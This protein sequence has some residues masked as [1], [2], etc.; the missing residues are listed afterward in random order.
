VSLGDPQ[1][2]GRY[3]LIRLVGAGGMAT[4]HLAQQIGPQGFV[5]PCV[6]KRIAEPFA[7]D[8]KYRRMF[9]Q[10]ARLS[11]LLNHP[12]VVQTFDFGEVENV[13][14]MAMELVDGVNLSVLCRGLAKMNRWIPL[15]ASV[16]ICVQVC[17]ALHYAHHMTALD[18][19]KLNLVHRDV[20]PQN[21][22]VSRQG[23]VKLAD[24]GIARH[25][26]R[27]EV[28]MGPT[29][30]GKPG[31]MAPEQAMGHDL[32]GR[33]DVFAVGVVLCEL[34]SA[35]RVN[36]GIE[37]PVSIIGLE[38]R[39]RELCAVRSEAPASLV[40]LTARLA[41]IDMAK[42][43][44][45]ARQVGQLLRAEADKL[46]AKDGLSGFLHRVFDRYFP[47]D[48]LP[49]AFHGSSGS[50]PMV[51]EPDGAAR[52]TKSV[53]GDVVEATEDQRATLLQPIDESIDEPI[54]ATSL[55]A[56][57]PDLM[58][59]PTIFPA[60][61]DEAPQQVDV[62][63][64]MWTQIG[65]VDEQPAAAFAGWP[66]EFQGNAQA[67]AEVRSDT[68]RDEGDAEPPPRGVS[69]IPALQFE[70]MPPSLP[71]PPADPS[72][73]ALA[74]DS[75]PAP[76]SGT[77]AE[78]FAPVGETQLDIGDD[79]IQPIAAQSQQTGPS[80]GPRSG[81]G[82]RP[83]AVVSPLSPPSQSMA[84]LELA[85]PA[86]K[87][88]VATPAPRSP[89]ED[90]V[91]RLGD[92]MSDSGVMTKVLLGIGAALLIA[93][94]V[95]AWV[96]LSPKA[97]PVKVA[98]GAI[99]VDSQP[100]GAEVLINGVGDGRFTPTTLE[101]LP[102]DVPIKLSARLK[103]Y[104]PVPVTK[105]VVIPA[106]MGRTDAFFEMAPAHV[107]T[108]S[109]TPPGAKVT[110]NGEAV[111]GRSPLDLPEVA[112]GD[113]ATIT[114]EL[115]TFLSVRRVL[116]ATPNAPTEVP[117]ALEKARLIEI[118]SDP[119]GAT[120]FLDDRE[121]GLTPEFDVPVP[122]VSAFNVRLERQG[123][124][125]WQRD[126]IGSKLTEDRVEAEL[127][128]V[129]LLALPLRREEREEARSLDRSLARFRSEIRKAKRK[130][131]SRLAQVERLSGDHTHVGPVVKAQNAADDVQKQVDQLE[132]ELEEA[133]AD[134]EEFRDRVLLRLEHS[135]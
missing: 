74:K 24:F 22:L 34:I 104:L 123:F 39:V 85:R 63:R 35:R 12:N 114:I 119:P 124:K 18:G 68:V 16:E 96:A 49:T 45:D 76:P 82:P 21:I 29:S 23:G 33:A 100:P 99:S 135:R 75:L 26:D 65:M 101:G 15:R 127:A 131:A 120:L 92:A 14:Y 102:V 54:D 95:A 28:T 98:G 109:T 5:K 4:V 107:F 59:A 108:I 38:D 118:A 56:A 62:V 93:G 10:E 89:M 125:K 88:E 71:A 27:I 37:G 6:L 86:P 17:D 40:D 117:I 64:D 2:F 78:A 90:A 42:R 50:L 36:K 128:D 61:P 41:D 13:P 87:V 132:I 60:A 133:Q 20:S 91:D 77:S 79:V 97:G 103:G 94:V 115:D 9:L 8:D 111:D 73:E 31:Y 112:E 121:I 129:P 134:V 57:P 106:T 47:P 80:G 70:S 11:A 66:A 43:P 130:L 72:A 84:P 116:R 51:S 55:D 53:S 19:Q 30:K 3:R 126:F 67:N 122:S 110:F 105:T 81:D 32:D 48:K 46:P 69:S 58:D 113:T 25:D 52:V 83:R 7:Y 44:D 1:M